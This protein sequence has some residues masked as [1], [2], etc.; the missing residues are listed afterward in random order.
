V[1]ALIAPPLAHMGHWAASLAYLVPI[2]VAI[3]LVTV[4]SV[5][6]RR[7]GAPPAAD[8]DWTDPRPPADP[9]ERR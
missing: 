2:V 4:Q 9:L 7:R 8:P 1:I 6:D 3:A 5:R